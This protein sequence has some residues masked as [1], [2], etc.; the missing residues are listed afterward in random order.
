MTI[1]VVRRRG[2][3]AA[4]HLF[5]GHPWCLRDSDWE[6]AWGVL[7][8][9]RIRDLLRV[10]R[11]QEVEEEIN[12]PRYLIC[13]TGEG[14]TR[15]RQD[16]EEP[17][18]LRQLIF[19][20][21]YD[22]ICAWLFANNGHDPLDLLVL[23]SR[24]EDVDDLDETG[25]PPNGRYPFCDHDVWDEWAG[26]EDA[27]QEMQEEEWIDEDEWLQADPGGTTRAP[28]GAGLIFAD[29]SDVSKLNRE[30]DPNRIANCQC[31][32]SYRESRALQHAGGIFHRKW[33]SR[34]DLIDLRRRQGCRS[35]VHLGL[36]SPR[37]SRNSGNLR[38][39]TH[40]QRIYS[41]IPGL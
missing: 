40:G 34:R 33:R 25:E 17:L 19:L 36:P 22:D 28:R 38:R 23:E 21:R 41:Q 37:C 14:A 8:T 31:R 35:L 6:I 3:P 7:A 10:V 13:A 20:N 9:P 2:A 26:V 32:T 16:A 1:H 5:L 4:Q 11:G 30:S 15:L 29:D 24:R 18:P 27:P 12:S 39:R